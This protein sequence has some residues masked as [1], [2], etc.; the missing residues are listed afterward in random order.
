MSEDAGKSGAEIT[1]QMGMDH[2]PFAFSSSL[3][4]SIFEAIKGWEVRLPGKPLRGTT[5]E[6]ATII[7]DAITAAYMENMDRSGSAGQHYLAMRRQLVDAHNELDRVSIERSEDGAVHSLPH[8]VAILAGRY[9]DNQRERVRLERVCQQTSEVEQRGRLRTDAWVTEV[10]YQAAGAASGVFLREDPQKV[11]PS[12]EVADAVAELLETFDIP[13]ACSDCQ[14]DRIKTG[15]IAGRR[16][17]KTEAMR[18]KIREDA[19]TPEDAKAAISEMEATGRAFMDGAGHHIGAQVAEEVLSDDERTEEEPEDEEFAGPLDVRIG[20]DGLPWISM[21]DLTNMLLT[22][23][24]ALLAER[25]EQE[26]EEFDGGLEVK[27]SQV[28]GP[29]V[30][31][32]APRYPRRSTAAVEGGGGGP[33]AEDLGLERAP[34]GFL[35]TA[36]ERSEG[37]EKKSQRK[38]ELVET[39]MRGFYKAQ[40]RLREL[41]AIYGTDAITKLADVRNEKQQRPVN[42]VGMRTW[43]G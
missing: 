1:K 42:M 34:R 23:G 32:S 10:A 19:A 8:R 9:I 37:I 7:A 28:D 17:G 21:L 24:D 13:R 11:T 15:Q 36:L 33:I 40:E 31:C 41:I 2:E 25:G 6:D 22:A 5:G 27:A 14:Q 29:R 39:E 16:W 4:E 20:P 38:Q 26:E 3:R 12:Q 30:C 43:V 18:E 35:E